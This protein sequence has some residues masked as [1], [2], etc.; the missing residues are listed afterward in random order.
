MA[1]I[2]RAGTG[3]LLAGGLLLA[4][5]M[6]YTLS[7]D[8][9]DTPTIPMARLADAADVAVFYPGR[10][11]WVEFRQGIAACVGPGRGRIVQEGDAM[12]VLE[13]PV[14]GRSLRFSWHRTRG[15]VET[16]DEV[17]RIARMSKPVA[18][19]GST[20]T[21]LT[22]ALAEALRDSSGTDRRGPVLLIPWATSVQVESP[23]P[24]AGRLD[25]LEIWRGRTFRFCP[26]NRYEAELLVRCLSEHE[27]EAKP[28]RV[29]V[30]V[31]RNDPYSKDLTA[32]F[33][34]AIGASEVAPGVEIQSRCADLSTPSPGG[35]DEVPTAWERQQAKEIWEGATRA[36]ADR[37][38]W[39][40]LPLQGRPTWRMLTALR[41]LAPYTADTVGRRLRVLCGDGIGL[42]TLTELAN[43]GLN[44]PVWCVSSA[45]IPVP[46]RSPPVANSATTQIQ[47]EIV[48][49]LIQCLD[50]PTGSA[51][52]LRDA[53]RA[54]D[55]ATEGPGAMRRSLA[56]T[57]T[58][59]RQ[60]K[61]LGH[62]FTA[63]PGRPEILAYARGSEGQWGDPVVI[64]RLRGPD[65]P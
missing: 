46:D 38:T 41:D 31:D 25:L 54:L 45:S 65:R 53:L 60:G 30:V 55:P 51:E 49:A 50:R 11:D 43:G 16:K 5:L 22:V 15:L 48:S 57:P 56:F 63:R 1:T 12:V 9:P 64:R 7:L 37:A 13:T 52:D 14:H 32:C 28:A 8:V 44:F 35:L 33:R 23:E 18:V 40:I 34:E 2:S 36:P 59:E 24:G 21:V 4:A 58:G 17:R 3:L 20:N 19:V 47:A 62:V 39:V 10:N 42:E 61:D 27:P 26:N 6:I 29:F